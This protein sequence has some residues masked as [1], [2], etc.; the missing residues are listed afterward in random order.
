MSHA[1]TAVLVLVLSASTVAAGE[2]PLES[3]LAHPKQY[4]GRH[5]TM[6]GFARVDGESFVLYRDAPSAKRLDVHA[7]SVAQR[8]G[9]PLHDSLNNR[10]VVVTGIIDAK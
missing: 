8:K 1:R 5:V 6:R 10:W 7:L 4:D 2:V 3:V 9:R